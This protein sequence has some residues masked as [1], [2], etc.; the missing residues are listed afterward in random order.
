VLAG[1]VHFDWIWIRFLKKILSGS[2]LKPMHTV[3]RLTIMKSKN[4]FIS[5]MTKNGQRFFVIA[6]EVPL[7]FVNLLFAKINFDRN[8]NEINFDGNPTR[9][10]NCTCNTSLLTL[11]WSICHEEDILAH[12]FFFKCCKHF[13]KDIGDK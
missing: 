3:P 9:N 5:K 6:K 1:P 8:S 4:L 13:P 11:V 12:F 10:G 2:D 7:Q